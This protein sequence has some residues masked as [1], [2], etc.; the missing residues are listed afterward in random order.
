[1]NDSAASQIPPAPDWW[2][3]SDDYW[4]PPQARPGGPPPGPGE[5]PGILPVPGPGPYGP[6]PYGASAASTTNR[7]IAI[8]IGAAVLGLIGI[9]VVSI[10]AITFLGQSAST[11]FSSVG[12][13]INSGSGGYNSDPANGECDFDRFMQDPDC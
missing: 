3:A 5:H 7:T 9:A 4:Y 13:S 12:T 10:L 11:K 6:G 1:M 8:V 2:L